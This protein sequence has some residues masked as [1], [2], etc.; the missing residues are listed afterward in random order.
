M[1]LSKN[2][3]YR[4][5]NEKD[6]PLCIYLCDTQTKNKILIIP[7]TDEKKDHSY[8]LSVT[9]QYAVL[10]AYCEINSASLISPLYLHSKPVR[11]PDRD[12]KVIQQHI[13]AD[14]MYQISVEAKSNADS[15]QVFEN[16]YQFLK[17]KWEKLLMNLL[18]Y[19]QKT[20]IYENGIYWVA[21]G[22][23]VGSELN[24]N[25]PALIWKKRV[26]GDCES[27][28]SYIIIPITSKQKNK[29][30]YMNV[31]ININERPCF[32][33]IEDMR[34]VNIKRISRPLTDAE[35]N[36]LFIDN[37]KRQEIIQAIGKFYIFENAHKDS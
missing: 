16:V 18:P 24:K 11:V 30:Y 12:I 32:L 10:Y 14:M 8:K 27:N 1:F 23:N 6:T 22:V 4:F 9:N 3:I 17:W 36:I 15:V 31:P 21:M 5:H 33:R 20:K 28:Y 29:R 2:T 26:S 25:R 35:G 13:I 7:L 19:H 37:Q 34:R